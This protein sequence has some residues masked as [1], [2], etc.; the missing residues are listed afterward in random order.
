M[1]DAVEVLEA[2][3]G[4]LGRYGWAERNSRVW[5]LARLGQPI[6]PKLQQ[7]RRHGPGR[8]R[9]VALEVLV[10]IVGEG[11]LHPA[12]LAA[13]ERL[14]R[15]KAP[16]EP[17]LNVS[18]CWDAWMCIRTGDQRGIMTSLGL[19]PVRPATF[20]LATTV[21]A[22]RIDDPNGLVFVTPEL[23]GWTVVAGRWCDP[24]DHERNEV[25]R[26]LVEKL[27]KQYSEAHA[28]FI[29]EY[30]EYSA[31]LIAKDGQTVRRYS[32]ELPALAIG[33]PL[34][35]ERRH[36]DALGVSVSPEEMHLKVEDDPAMDEAFSDFSYACTARTVAAD[37]SIDIVGGLH[38]S[39][40]VVRG[41]GMLARIPGTSATT[42]S[43]GGYQI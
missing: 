36:L 3:L 43:P 13:A 1:S 12:D 20:A 30:S 2:E 37:L 9:A 29:D 8:L 35:I 40:S 14:V 4:E 38:R 41:T 25:V 19:A 23:N 16:L 18:L 26:Q 10:M 39:A 31:W 34:P 28:F 17:F 6:V 33:R 22:D 27:S 5:R 24:S 21:V 32:E 15:I 7:I 11:G 42:I